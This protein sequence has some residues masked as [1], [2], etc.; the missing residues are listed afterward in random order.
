MRGPHEPSKPRGSA[1]IYS[2]RIKS[3]SVLLVAAA[4][5]AT[6]TTTTRVLANSPFT[7]VSEHAFYASQLLHY[8]VEG[9]G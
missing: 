2:V 6:L 9:I 3:R 4:D 8:T 5:S 1:K 7:I